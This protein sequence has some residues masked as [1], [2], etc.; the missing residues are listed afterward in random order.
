[1]T[2]RLETSLRD[3]RNTAMDGTCRFVPV[4]FPC[5]LGKLIF[6]DYIFDPLVAVNLAPDFPK[7]CET[8]NEWIKIVVLNLVSNAKKHGPTGCVVEVKLC[9][10]SEASTI[11]IAVTDQGVGVSPARSRDIWSGDETGGRI[12]IGAI[13]SYIDGLGGSYGNDG[14]TFWFQ[15]PGGM[16][17]SAFTMSPWT[18]RFASKKAEQK[19]V[20]VGHQPS[21]T[22]TT[23]I[24]L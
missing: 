4:I 11:H 3:G 19:F 21:T 20:E 17:H 15:V 9:W 13:R 10:R 2:E 7:L 6:E 23:V 22:V 16:T 14:P 5:N 12:G 18:L 1:M 8:D 24:I